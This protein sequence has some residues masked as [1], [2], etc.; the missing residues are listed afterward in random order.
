M[1]GRA[2][3]VRKSK[4]VPTTPKAEAAGESS[5]LIQADATGDN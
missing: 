2:K 4:P 3:Q 5:S 1:S